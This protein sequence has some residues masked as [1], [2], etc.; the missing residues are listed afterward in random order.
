MASAVTG[1]VSIFSFVSLVGI[2]I[3]FISSAL[4]IKIFPL[5]RKIEKYKLIIKKKN[6]KHDKIVFFEKTKLHSIE[7]LISKA[8]IDILVMMNL[9]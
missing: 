2:V 5:T 3:G 8:L 4:G 7:V 6:K 9:F 1:Y